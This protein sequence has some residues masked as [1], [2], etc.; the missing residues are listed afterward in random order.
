MELNKKGEI[1]ISILQVRRKLYN[2]MLVKSSLEKQSFHKK[3][4]AF[5]VDP[6]NYRLPT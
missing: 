2:Q 4:D 6:S 5:E 1:C 3:W